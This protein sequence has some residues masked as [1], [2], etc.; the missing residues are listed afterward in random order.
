MLAGHCDCAPTTAGGQRLNVHRPTTAG[1]PW[2]NECAFNRLCVCGR[3][4]SAPTRVSCW[5]RALDLALHRQPKSLFADG[6][7]RPRNPRAWSNWHHS[8]LRPRDVTA[9]YPVVGY[10]DL[11][12]RSTSKGS[13][14][15]NVCGR[16]GEGRIMA[17]GN[18]RSTSEGSSSG[19]PHRQ[20]SSHDGTGIG[21][22]PSSSGGVTGDTPPTASP[23]NRQRRRW[24]YSCNFSSS[25]YNKQ[26]TNTESIDGRPQSGR[27]AWKPVCS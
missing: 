21:A 26:R 16:H 3:G 11:A 6:K 14:L 23:H 19:S 10:G 17:V 15:S 25:S 2:L 7:T 8:S 24:R 1:G 27:N 9:Q 22:A 18:G 13:R 4:S 5:T 20:R 12:R